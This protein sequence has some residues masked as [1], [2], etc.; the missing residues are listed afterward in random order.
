MGTEMEKE[1]S[2]FEQNKENLNTKSPEGK[3]QNS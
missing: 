3:M 1:A 2:D